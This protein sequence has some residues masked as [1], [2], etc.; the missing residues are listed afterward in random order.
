[1]FKI[2]LHLHIE[3]LNT[4]RYKRDYLRYRNIQLSESGAAKVFTN[5][6]SRKHEISK[7]KDHINP[8]RISYNLQ[9]VRKIARRNR[10]H[11]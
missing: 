9:G 5:L 4:S 10:Q 11:R 7:L 2:Y 1:M 8:R 6:T 3:N